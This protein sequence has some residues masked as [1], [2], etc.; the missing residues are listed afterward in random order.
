MN[1]F[2]NIKGN[3]RRSRCSWCCDSRILPRPC[4]TSGTDSASGA[5]RFSVTYIHAPCRWYSFMW[6]CAQHCVYMPIPKIFINFNLFQN[7]RK[8][9]LSCVW[10]KWS[11]SIIQLLYMLIIPGIYCK[12]SSSLSQNP[13]ISVL[14]YFFVF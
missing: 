4:Q 10:K 7:F 1:T 3:S 6:C 11:A 12:Q 5:P 8:L 2:F 13:C 14:S 9:F